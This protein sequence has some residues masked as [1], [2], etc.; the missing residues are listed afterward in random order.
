MQLIATGTSFAGFCKES[1]DFLVQ[2]FDLLPTQT[3]EL[4]RLQADSRRGQHPAGHL[5]MMSSRIVASAVA[6]EVTRRKCLS[7]QNPPPY[8][9]GYHS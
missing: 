8:V 4:K 3:D 2:T 1:P 7:R 5:T 6:A 9:G